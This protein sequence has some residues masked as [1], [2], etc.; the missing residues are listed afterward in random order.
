MALR[1]L[2]IEVGLER[3]E[4]DEL[5]KRRRPSSCA[6]DTAGHADQEPALA[7]DHA[8]VVDESETADVGHEVVEGLRHSAS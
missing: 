8:L 3:F 4:L 7:V 6:H 5:A 2:G 1:T